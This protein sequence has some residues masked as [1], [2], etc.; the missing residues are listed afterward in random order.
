MDFGVPQ[1]IVDGIGVTAGMLTTASFV[2]QLIRTWRMKSAR[3]LSY[4]WLACFT[5]GLLS[6]LTY[7]IL[8]HSA[9]VI[10]ANTCTLILVGALLV[11]KVKF[12]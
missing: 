2:P 8:I 4:G 9:P 1:K 3:D 10:I 6:W 11:M 12:G 5:G 7:G